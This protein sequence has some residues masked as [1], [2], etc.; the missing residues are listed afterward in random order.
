MGLND[1]TQAPGTFHTPVAAR[2]DAA[3][4]LAVIV[5]NW[6]WPAGTI[7][8]SEI[9]ERDAGRHASRRNYTALILLNDDSAII[10][11]PCS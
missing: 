4:G 1:A 7:F 11:P 2:A 6:N 5:K 8:A 10:R 3:D 9:G